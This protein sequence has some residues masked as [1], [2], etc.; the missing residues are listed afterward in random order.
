MNKRSG[1][2]Y[3]PEFNWITLIVGRIRFSLTWEW[4]HWYVGIS[5]PYEG[6]G[7]DINI[8]PFEFGFLILDKG[9]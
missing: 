4:C 1:F 7:M 3:D 2:D 5:F 9:E 6:I 8:L